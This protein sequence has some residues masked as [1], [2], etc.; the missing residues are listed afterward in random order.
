[1][2]T[3]RMKAVSQMTGI[4]S[5][6]LRM[7]ER[8]YGLFKPQRADNRYREFDDEDVR[9]LLY[10]REQIEAG[11]SIGELASEGRE[12]LLRR[13]T[14]ATEPVA[15]SAPTVVDE[16]LQ[17][18]CELDKR[19]L[20]ARLAELIVC[21]PFFTLLTTV[22]TSLMH[23]L[24]DAW[25]RDETSIASVLL[26]TELIRARLLAM[27]QSTA[28][29]HAAPILLCAC[30]AGESHELGL[31]T[32]AYAMQQEGWHAY[33]LGANLPLVA[34]QEACARIQP[35]LVALSLTYIPDSVRYM[36]A[37]NQIDVG[38]AAWY[39]T[40]VGGQL[41]ERHAHA[42]SISHLQICRSLAEAKQYGQRLQARGRLTVSTHQTFNISRTLS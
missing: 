23:R 39:P 6:L 15:S 25:K 19:R 14:K 31:L 13:L 12:A 26:M 34:L 42:E 32:L 30:P 9:L 28:P 1:M 18:A 35:A 2:G 3:Y 8:R 24:G 5:E 29:H 11:R 33:Y 7:W 41:V 10:L 38:I 17:A 36:D 37:L 20:D 16:L 40:C 4:R 27:L 21:T 22:L